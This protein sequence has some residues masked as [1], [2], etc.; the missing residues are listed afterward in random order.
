M[1][2]H[3]IWNSEIDLKDWQ[4]YLTECYPD[5]IDENEQ[6]ELCNIMNG[7][8]LEDERQNLDIDLPGMIIEVGTV[9]TWHGNFSG[10]KEHKTRNIGEC[11]YSNVHGYS[12]NEWYFDGYN[13]RHIERHHDGTN[14]TMLRMLRPGLTDWQIDNFLD[15]IYNNRC[16]DRTMRRYTL[17]IAPYVKNV[18]GW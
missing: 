3:V 13:I 5:I 17:S 11:L 2:K 18:Y 14:Y 12:E 16:N 4:D 6:F 9:G 8:Y 10:Y 7:E 1:K 15:S